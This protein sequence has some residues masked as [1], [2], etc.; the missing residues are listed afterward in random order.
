MSSRQHGRQRTSRPSQAR[1]GQANV[2]RFTT[3]AWAVSAQVLGQR[4]DRTALFDLL[5]FLH[6]L[7][8]QNAAAIK[9]HRPPLP[10]KPGCCYC[11]YVGP[12]RPDLLGSEALRIAAFLNDAGGGRLAQVRSRLAQVGTAI[13]DGSEREPGRQPCLFLD[14]ERCLVYP[15]R[16]LRC[17]AQYSPDV[18]ACRQYHVGQRAT[19]PL[20]SELALLYQSLLVGFRLGLEEAGLSGAG[21]ALTPA[22]TAALE[23][24][25]VSRRWLN[26]EAVF[27]ASRL[28][29]QAD[30]ERLMARLAR[31]A[32][33]EVQ[34]EKERMQPL[35][36]L[37]LDRPGA[38]ALYST[39]GVAPR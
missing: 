31:Q 17:R 27:E 13:G 39:T 28:A 34:G 26:H 7:S 5:G 35:V 6:W 12:D 10:C 22:I 25:D 3:G 24:P 30:E 14:Q 23:E 16:P 36:S 8:D 38:W 32:R 29:Q 18:E 11:C 20:L 15:V 1:P 9:Q 37:F 19:M 21:L 4:R 33:N 2:K